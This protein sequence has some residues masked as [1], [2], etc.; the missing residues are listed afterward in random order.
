MHMT[1]PGRAPRTHLPVGRAIRVSDDSDDLDDLV[2]GV[3][4]TPPRASRPIG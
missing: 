2:T 4:V 3:G 1:T